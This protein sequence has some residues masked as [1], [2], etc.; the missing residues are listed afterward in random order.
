MDQ[1]DLRVLQVQQ[2]LLVRRVRLVCVVQQALRALRVPL[3]Q[4]PD[5]PEPLDLLVSRVR[6]AQ[7]DP[8][9]LLV[10]QAPK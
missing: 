8:L 4:F 2:A 7:P 10:P 5:Q 9:V 3:P 1:P 6:L